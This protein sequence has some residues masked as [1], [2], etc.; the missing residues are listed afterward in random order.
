MTATPMVPPPRAFRPTN[1]VLYELVALFVVVRG[2]SY[3]RIA[4]VLTESGYRVAPS[5]VRRYVRHV[6]HGTG[7][8]AW[9]NDLRYNDGSG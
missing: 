8:L 2:W 7:L 4:R 1:P 6:R 5:T 3:R 9:V